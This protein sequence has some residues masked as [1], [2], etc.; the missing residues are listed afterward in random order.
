MR[1]RGSQRGQVDNLRGQDAGGGSAHL[2]VTQ[3]RWISLLEPDERLL[4]SAVRVRAYT[5]SV[6]TSFCVPIMSPSGVPK[7][8]P[9]N[10]IVIHRWMAILLALF[11]CLIVIPLGHG[12]V[13][14]ALSKLTPRYGWVHGSPGFWNW[15]GL[16]PVGVATALLIWTLIIGIAH[17]P[18]AVRLGLVPSVLVTD[19]PYRFTRNPMYVAEL[20]LWLGWTLFFGSL[21][22]FLGCIAL[23]LV[24]NLVLVPREERTLEAVFGQAYLMYKKRVPRWL[25]QANSLR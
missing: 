4:V 8:R 21:S 1:T 15:L 25:A 16:I 19:G 22:V 18:K 2:S 24:M 5:A 6:S 14:L 11:V 12:A 20:A 23:L 13:P 7:S 3:S 17:A 10:R 9:P